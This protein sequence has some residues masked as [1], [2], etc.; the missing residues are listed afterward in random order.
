MSLVIHYPTNFQT[1][2]QEILC[3]LG[4]PAAGLG[5]KLKQQ[6][7]KNSSSVSSGRLTTLFRERGN[8]AIRWKVISYLTHAEQQGPSYTLDGVWRSTKASGKRPYLSR[9]FCSCAQQRGILKYHVNNHGISISENRPRTESKL[10]KCL[11]EVI[12]KHFTKNNPLKLIISLQI[13]SKSFF[14]LLTYLW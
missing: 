12:S 7:N 1:H 3:T 2:G 10:W 5:T 13:N 11:Y 14:L 6:L 9:D 4:P 8:N